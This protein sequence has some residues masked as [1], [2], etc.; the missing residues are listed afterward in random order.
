MFQSTRPH[1]ARHVNDPDDPGGETFQSTRPHGA[2]PNVVLRIYDGSRFQSTRPHGARLGS[3]GKHGEPDWVSI[4]APARGATRRSSYGLRH[5]A[6]FNPRARTGR[7]L[8]VTRSRMPFKSFQSTRPHGARPG[9]HRHRLYPT[10]FNPRA[11]TGRDHSGLMVRS[12]ATMF[13][14]TRPHGARRA[15]A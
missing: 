14:S 1:G 10:R 2:R 6:G 11:R 4:H 3:A 13:Q 12:W 15:G 7:D 8:T 9:G 5:L